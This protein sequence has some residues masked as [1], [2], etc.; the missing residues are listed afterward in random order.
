MTNDMTATVRDLAPAVN[1][2]FDKLGLV[3]DLIE[4]EGQLP[5]RLV[6][7]IIGT[8]LNSANR[9]L[10]AAL[11]IWAGAISG[12]ERWTVGEDGLLS[13]VTGRGET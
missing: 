12:N 13:E 2:A 11:E 3:Q 7:G 10:A 1:E 5:E 8:A 9:N 4:A 6:A